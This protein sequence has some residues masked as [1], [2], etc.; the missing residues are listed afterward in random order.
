MPEHQYRPHVC[1]QPKVL[2]AHFHRIY[3]RDS[4]YASTM[5]PAGDDSIAFMCVLLCSELA[6][7][8]VIYLVLVKERFFTSLQQQAR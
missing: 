1:G 8:Y 5:L 2:L 4:P 7:D 3:A 6:Q